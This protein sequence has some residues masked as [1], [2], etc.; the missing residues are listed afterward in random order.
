MPEDGAV[1]AGG[2]VGRPAGLGGGAGGAGG[3]RVGPADPDDAPF[4]GRSGQ[5]GQDRVEVGAVTGEEG[6]LSPPDGDEPD[7]P[8]G[9]L[10]PYGERVGRNGLAGGG[11]NGLA[12]GGRNGLAGGD[13]N[14]LAGGD[15]NGLA[16]G[17]RSGSCPAGGGRGGHRC[18]ADHDGS[19]EG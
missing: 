6:N 2:E 3:A 10:V 15:R 9:Q 8:G 13:R 16:G 5:F 1:E 7:A 18:R 14:G 11:R 19:A 12:G 17:G 4:A